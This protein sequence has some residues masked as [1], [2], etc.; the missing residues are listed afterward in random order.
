VAEQRGR[1]FDEKLLVE[2][3]TLTTSASENGFKK[4]LYF[5]TY[6]EK[7]VLMGVTQM[8]V[9]GRRWTLPT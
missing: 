9:W 2:G 4:L 1:S 7:Q 8:V 5:L 6:F 3:E